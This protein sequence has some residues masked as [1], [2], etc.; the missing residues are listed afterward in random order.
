MGS[1]NVRKKKTS[2]ETVSAESA[3]STDLLA[4]VDIAIEAM[5]VALK[6]KGCEKGSLSDLIRLLQ[7]RKELNAERPRHISVRWIDEDE[8]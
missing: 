1:S 3:E 6:A 5:K 7:L 4:T 2:R 8:C